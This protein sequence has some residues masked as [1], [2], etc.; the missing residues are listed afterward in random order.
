MDDTA[1]LGWGLLA[2]GLGLVYTIAFSSI[3]VQITALAGSNGV[4][5]FAPLLKQ[6]RHD[7]PRTHWFHFPM[8]FWL[9]GASDAALRLV[10]LGGALLGIAAALGLASQAALVGCWLAFRSLDLPVGL[11]YPWDCLLLEAGALATLLP[12]LPPVSA[13]VAAAALPHPW[14]VLYV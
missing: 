3:A 14:C 4:A 11:L 10:P 8:L 7:F 12:A 1:L 13:S 5:P 6:M 9:T 2:R